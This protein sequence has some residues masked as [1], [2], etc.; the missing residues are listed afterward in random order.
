MVVLLLLLARA[1]G[2][3]ET[4][5]DQIVAQSVG[6]AGVRRHA[7]LRGLARPQLLLLLLL[8]LIVLLR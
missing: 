7:L 3:V 5:R 8:L 4:P 1:G 2:G 6:G